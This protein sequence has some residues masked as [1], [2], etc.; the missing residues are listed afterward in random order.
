MCTIVNNVTWQNSVSYKTPFLVPLER[1]VISSMATI[2]MVMLA[3]TCR[4]ILGSSVLVNSDLCSSLSSTGSE[5]MCCV[6]M[7]CD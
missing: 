7:A 3:L 1:E 2:V 6:T 4:D 5:K